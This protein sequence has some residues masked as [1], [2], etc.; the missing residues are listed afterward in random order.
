MPVAA[1][2]LVGVSG[3]LASFAMI[4]LITCV[5]L[6]QRRHRQTQQMTSTESITTDD[7]D[8]KPSV[9]DS[10][11]GSCSP[12]QDIAVSQSTPDLIGRNGGGYLATGRAPDVIDR[13]FHLRCS[14]AIPLSYYAAR[15]FINCLRVKSSMRTTYENPLLHHWWRKYKYRLILAVG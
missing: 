5:I 13:V 14:V 2:L 3:G 4:G 9:S 10:D 15:Q 8:E 7:D 6:S 1:W 11:A 12:V